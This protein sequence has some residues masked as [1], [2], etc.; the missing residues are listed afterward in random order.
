MA[1]LR[2][3]SSN[4]PVSGTPGPLVHSCRQPDRPSGQV[5]NSLSTV[6]LTNDSLSGN[7]F[8]AVLIK[9]PRSHCR[10]KEIRALCRYPGSSAFSYLSGVFFLGGDMKGRGVETGCH[11]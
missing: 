10:H 3:T 5:G 11:L 6:G 7:L 4:G 8:P 2:L 9:R 1:L